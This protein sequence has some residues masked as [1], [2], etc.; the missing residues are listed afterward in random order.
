MAAHRWIPILWVP[1][2]KGVSVDAP[3]RGHLFFLRD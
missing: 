2:Q 3:L 1:P